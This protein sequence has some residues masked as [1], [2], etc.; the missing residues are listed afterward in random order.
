MTVYS[1]MYFDNALENKDFA[2]NFT[3]LTRAERNYRDENNQWDS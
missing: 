1:S 2:G 3:F